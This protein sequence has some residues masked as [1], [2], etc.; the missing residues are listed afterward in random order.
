MG[1]QSTVCLMGVGSIRAVIRG[2]MAAV[3]RLDG[4]I[5]KRRCGCGEPRL[6]WRR[7]TSITT[8]A[9]TGGAISR[10]SASAATCF[11]TGHTIWRNDGSR[12]CYAARLAT[13]SSALIARRRHGL[14]AIR[15]VSTI[16]RPSGDCAFLL[17]FERLSKNRSSV[18]VNRSISKAR[19]IGRWTIYL[20]RISDDGCPAAKPRWSSR[21]VTTGSRWRKHCIFTNSPKKNSALGSARSNAMVLLACGQP[22]FSNIV[23]RASSSGRENRA[24][25]TTRFP[26]HQT[27]SSGG[28]LTRQIG[29]ELKVAFAGSLE[30]CSVGPLWRPVCLRCTWRSPGRGADDH[31]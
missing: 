11:T 17:G 13:C 6:Y 30:F 19:N 10:A 12:T 15:F 14:F 29:N 16:T 28:A 20:P 1:S 5:S 21:C 8:R 27:R 22:A 3:G 2:V 24:R 26:R 7:R 9:I 25:I 18:P 31:Y 4:P 23:N